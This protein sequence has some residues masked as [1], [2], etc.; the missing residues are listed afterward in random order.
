MTDQNSVFIATRDFIKRNLFDRAQTKSDEEGYVINLDDSAGAIFQKLID[1]RYSFGAHNKN[2]AVATVGVAGEDDPRYY[3]IEPRYDAQQ[4]L[5]LED[6]WTNDVVVGNGTN[7]YVYATVGKHGKTVLDTNKEFNLESDRRDEVSK[8]T[9]NERYKKAKQGVDKVLESELVNFFTEFTDLVEESTVFGRAASFRIMDPTTG[10]LSGLIH[11]DPK[12]LGRVRVS[13]D[14]INRI[15]AVEYMDCIV[16]S[17][18]DGSENIQIAL[19]SSSKNNDEIKPAFIPIDKLIYLIHSF[20]SIPKNARY[21]GYSKLEGVVHMSQ[22]KRIIINENAKESA[23]AL[24]AG[25]GIMEFDPATPID[26]M[27][28]IVQNVKR[29]VG[30]WFGH[31]AGIVTKREVWDMKPAIDKFAVLVDMINREILRCLGLASFLVGYEQIANY[32]NSEQIMLAMRE[33]DV[34]HIRTRFKDFIKHVV[35]DPIFYYFLA[36]GYDDT[37]QKVYNNNNAM[38]DNRLDRII[39][40]PKKDLDEYLKRLIEDEDVKLTYEFEDL[41]FATK[42]ELAAMFEKVKL[43]IPALP[44][45]AILRA[46]GLENYIEEVATEEKRRQEEMQRQLAA[47]MVAQDQEDKDKG[48]NDFE[49]RG[50]VG[51]TDSATNYKQGTQPAR[52]LA[53]VASQFVNQLNDEEKAKLMELVEV[54]TKVYKKALEAS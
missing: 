13:R 17:N 20:G 31:K 36:F 43:M 8:V 12:R 6:A 27:G 50:K 26:L 52:N 11:L 5:M 4:L 49:K 46:L 25:I 1:K 54:Q 24:Y 34:A 16:N 37:G 15:D 51:G 30:R 7:K 40:I 32:A 29:S 9:K 14:N 44:S 21:V 10:I 22:V 23:K 47:G 45:E 35:I 38:K 3:Y 28:E 19:E 41:N 42:L 39:D 53:A 2:A 48:K 33:M 18:E